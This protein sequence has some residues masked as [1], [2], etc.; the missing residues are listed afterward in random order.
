MRKLLKN[1]KNERVRNNIC[2]YLKEGSFKKDA[3]KMSGINESTLYRWM[4]KDA[5][6]ASQV[7]ANILEFKYS[8]IKNMN[9]YAM[10]N[11]M[12]A[13]KILERRWPKEWAAPKRIRYEQQR[14]VGRV[15]IVDSLK[16]F[17]EMNI[18]SRE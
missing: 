8:L 16:E 3:A 1:L 12:F 10:K 11:G 15:I 4:Q 13:L 17:N 6:F 2:E 18:G 14:P 5:S 7:E 9:K